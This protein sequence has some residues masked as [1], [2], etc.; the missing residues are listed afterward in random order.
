M[1]KCVNTMN[2]V[3]VRDFQ[4]KPRDYLK[5]L[6]ITLTR[7]GK[8]IAVI[9]KASQMIKAGEVSDKP[10][11]GYKFSETLNKYVKC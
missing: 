3:S 11:E 5:S 6:P 8:D 10:L 2:R 7:Y 4:L 9:Q 1:L